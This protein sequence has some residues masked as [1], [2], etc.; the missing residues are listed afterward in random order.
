M[1]KKNTMKIR[2]NDKRLQNRSLLKYAPNPQHSLQ[3]L[4]AKQVQQLHFLSSQNKHYRLHMLFNQY[5]SQLCRR[6]GS[7]DM[8]NHYKWQQ[9]SIS[10]TCS[11]LTALEHNSSVVHFVFVT[12]S[13]RVIRLQLMHEQK[14]PQCAEA[15]KF[16]HQNSSQFVRW[17]LIGPS[18][19]QTCRPISSVVLQWAADERRTWEVHLGFDVAWPAS[20]E[21]TGRIL[22]QLPSQPAAAYL[23]RR[24][25]KL[26]ARHFFCT[27]DE[28]DVKCG[29]NTCDTFIC[30]HY[31]QLSHSNSY[32][33]RLILAA[34]NGQSKG[35]GDNQIYI[36]LLIY[37]STSTLH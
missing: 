15:N 11:S 22:Q 2:S 34:F 17:P 8:A 12:S 7:S 33:C 32:R 25:K 20:Y 9:F 5:K 3:Q 19:L 4:R 10:A 27:G 30:R 6:R 13:P 29:T 31:F 18:Y 14:L 23:E 26:H 1:H 16:R 36:E 24:G 28:R 37:I 35:V 21:L